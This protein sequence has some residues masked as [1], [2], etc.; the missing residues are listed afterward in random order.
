MKQEKE[1]IAQV[2]NCKDC[3]WFARC[4][5]D[6]IC[7][8][9]EDFTPTGDDTYCENLEM[10]LKKHVVP[11]RTKRMTLSGSNYKYMGMRQE[12][13]LNQY[14]CEFINDAIR[15]LKKGHTAYVFKISQIADIMSFLPD[16]HIDAFK[17]GIFYLNL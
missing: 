15:E 14:Y 2:A 5:K 13:T 8:I 1:Y 11:A 17:D 4:K 12:T 7:R 6:G 3:M 9:C 16:I 10:Y